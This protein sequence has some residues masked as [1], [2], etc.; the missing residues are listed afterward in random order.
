MKEDYDTMG[1]EATI[2]TAGN[3]GTGKALHDTGIALLPYHVELAARE[4]AEQF[5]FCFQLNNREALT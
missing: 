5:L 4:V 3:N 2:Q 1:P